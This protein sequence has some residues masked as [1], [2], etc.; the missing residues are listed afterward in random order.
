MSRALDR[1]LVALLRPRTVRELAEQLGERPQT[2]LLILGYLAN[3][4][5]VINAGPGIFE[6]HP[7]ARHA[8]A[9]LAAIWAEREAAAVRH[10]A[11]LSGAMRVPDGDGARRFWIEDE[12]D[13]SEH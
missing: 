11:D 12:E 1:A 2:A 13:H 10:P 7:R 5:R 3:E 9:R 6:I 8:Y 4:G